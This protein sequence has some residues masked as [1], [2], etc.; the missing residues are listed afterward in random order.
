MAGSD[1]SIDENTLRIIEGAL[2]QIRGSNNPVSAEKLWALGDQVDVTKLS[3]HDADSL[4]SALNSTKFVFRQLEATKNALFLLAHSCEQRLST[5]KL[6]MQPY[7]LHSGILSLPDDVLA[8][9]F[10]SSLLDGDE[11]ENMH[12]WAEH[13]ISYVCR[14]FR[15]ISL[16]L[17]KLWS[18]VTSY[19]SKKWVDIRLL[20]SKTVGLAVDIHDNR[21]NQYGNTISRFG[22]QVV[23]HAHRWQSFRLLGGDLSTPYHSLNQQLTQH[24]ANLKLPA[25]TYFHIELDMREEDS[26]FDDLEFY[27]TWEM[28]KLRHSNISHGI[29]TDAM[30][31][32]Q[33]IT[34]FAFTFARG[35]LNFDFKKLMDLLSSL[36]NLTDL[37][38][39]LINYDDYN[40]DANLADRVVLPKVESFTLTTQIFEAFKVIT[41]SVQ[42][43]TLTKLYLDV[44]VGDNFSAEQWLDLVSM[45]EH[46]PIKDFTFI[47]RDH[48]ESTLNLSTIFRQF[49]NTQSL[50][51]EMPSRIGYS[52]FNCSSLPPLRTL[53]LNHTSSF[54][55]GLMKSLVGMFKQQGIWN[56]I[57]TLEVTGD[58]LLV[59]EKI[60]DVERRI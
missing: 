12:P 27:R 45:E 2:N 25:L 14:R 13:C 47:Y 24:F 58:R 52:T 42:M 32:S 17:P 59:R 39:E 28:P 38:L 33:T 8:L 48:Y 22:Q 30:Y 20:R 54:S 57:E 46:F 9:I 43:P 11:Y 44:S 5:L 40:Y 3:L 36:D 29:P 34:S 31:G 18:H 23:P 6:E 49:P 10:E 7:F 56:E 51:L 50:T 1:I 53:S 15:S 35:T 26:D 4:G 21:Y 16:G 41:T 55:S 19:M 37:S 60:E